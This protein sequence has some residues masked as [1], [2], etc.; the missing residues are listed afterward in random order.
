MVALVA[1]HPSWVPGLG[2]LGFEALLHN[3]GKNVKYTKYDI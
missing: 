2:L 1:G 3:T